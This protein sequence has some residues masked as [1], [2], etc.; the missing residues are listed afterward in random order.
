M[1]DIPRIRATRRATSLLPACQTVGKSASLRG[2]PGALPAELTPRACIVEPNAGY[3]FSQR[4]RAP[5][6]SLMQS[7]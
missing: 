1:S 3:S 5:P 6:P 2:F 4:L 7:G